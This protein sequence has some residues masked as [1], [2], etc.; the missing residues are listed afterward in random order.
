MTIYDDDDIDD[1]DDD[2]RDDNDRYLW[3]LECTHHSAIY[4]KKCFTCITSTVIDRVHYC[5]YDANTSVTYRNSILSP[6]ENIHK[7][8][9]K[10]HL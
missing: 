8:L 4:T 5:S 9:R 3:G 10:F 6:P 2:D 1:D 7:P